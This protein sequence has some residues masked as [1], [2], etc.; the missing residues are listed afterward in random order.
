MDCQLPFHAQK[1]ME[2]L[3]AMAALHLLL[4]VFYILKLTKIR[5]YDFDNQRKKRKI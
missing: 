5:I 2:V 3:T 1:E 4:Y